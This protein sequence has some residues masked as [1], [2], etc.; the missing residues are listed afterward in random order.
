M[1]RDILIVE[2]KPDA[3]ANYGNRI[4]LTLGIEP[5]LAADAGQAL[6]ILHQYSVKVLVTD[7]DLGTNQMTGTPANRRLCERSSALPFLVSCYRICRSG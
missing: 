1:A 6:N 7:Q 5:F 3:L 4:R 2:D